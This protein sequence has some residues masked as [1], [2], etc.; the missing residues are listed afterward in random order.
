MQLSV[1][2]LLKP[3]TRAGGRVEDDEDKDLDVPGVEGGEGLEGEQEEDLLHLD[4]DDDMLSDVEEDTFADELDMDEDERDILL[5]E[6]A[7]VRET[8][9]KVRVRC[10]WTMQ[11]LTL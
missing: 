6:T 1:R 11:M 9:T 7:V 8:I 2:T 3:F 10:L 5:V 4:I